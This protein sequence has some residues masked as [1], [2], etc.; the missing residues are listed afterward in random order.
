[1]KYNDL[2]TTDKNKIENII[3][4]AELECISK[5]V[6]LDE[7]IFQNSSSSLN[8]NFLTAQLNI[9]NDLNK[10]QNVQVDNKRVID[11]SIIVSI[12]EI[13]QNDYTL[14]YKSR[15][16]TKK[17]DNYCCLPF[18]IF[19]FYNHESSVYID[20]KIDVLTFLQ[21]LTKEEIT[22]IGEYHNLYYKNRIFTF[23]LNKKTWIFDEKI[24][25]TNW[26]YDNICIYVYK[27]KYYN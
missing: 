19:N 18:L 2:F 6:L 22:M 27:Q 12:N 8:K 7:S 26:L 1:M 25:I 17:N 10:E 24:L 16:N 14:S 23:V 21:N 5:Q 20:D 13:I 3:H 4:I 15:T 11:A 9:Q